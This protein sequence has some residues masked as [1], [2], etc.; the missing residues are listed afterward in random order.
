[1]FGIGPAGILSGKAVTRRGAVRKGKVKC[2]VYRSLPLCEAEDH[3]AWNAAQ[4][5]CYPMS[6]VPSSR[7]VGTY[8]RKYGPTVAKRAAAKRA[9]A[10][11]PWL[12]HV[13][14]VRA[15]NPHLSYKLAL[16]EASKTYQKK[17]PVRRRAKVPPCNQYEPP[18]H[19]LY[20]RRGK[21][22]CRVSAKRRKTGGGY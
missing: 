2:N 19:T 4:N 14:Q 21:S 9:A 1:M 13:R 15:A 18:A 7:R 3:C 12:A 11:N 8:K 22:F 6:R 10:K 5:K 20:K 16:K 17:G